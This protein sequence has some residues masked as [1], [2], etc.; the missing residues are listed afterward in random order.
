MSLNTTDATIGN[1]LDMHAVENLPNEFRGDPANLLRIQAG[2]VSA[3]TNQGQA[4]LA[5]VDPNHTRDGAVAGASADQNN[6]SVDGIDATDVAAGGAFS[7]TQ[8]AIPVDAIQEFN[9][10]IAQ[11]SAAFGGRSG[12]Q[13][14]ITTKSGTNDWHGA[15]FEYNRTAATEA[16]TFFNNQ[17]GV[18]RLALIRNQFGGNVGGPVLKD[19]LFFFFEYDGR[20][21]RSA[22][23]ELQFVPFPHV[24]QGEI[25]YVNNRLPGLQ[26]F[27]FC[28]YAYQLH[29]VCFRRDSEIA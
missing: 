20:R 14:N 22:Q 27:D 8:A 17:T 16:N 12:A 7:V 2:V 25:A 6:I 21:D 18:P 9:T 23:N 28:R 11:P 26:P 13:T 5:N 24:A 10:Q 3:Q 4:I 1:N 29:I 15:L 19:K